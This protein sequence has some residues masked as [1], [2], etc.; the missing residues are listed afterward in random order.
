ME[1]SRRCKTELLNAGKLLANA[2]RT[3][4]CKSKGQVLVTVRAGIGEKR[5][6]H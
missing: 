5:V 3:P 4:T 2:G 1:K 6:Q